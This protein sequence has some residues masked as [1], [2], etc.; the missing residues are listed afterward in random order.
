[1]LKR[2][3]LSCLLCAL[4]VCSLCI[5]ASAA[6]EPN[7]LYINSPQ[8]FLDFSQSCRLDSYSMGLTVYLLRDISLEGLEFSGVPIFSGTFHGMGHRISGVSITQSGSNMGLF[9]FLT[10]TAVVTDLRVEGSIAPGGSSSAAGGIAGSNAGLISGC[11][12]TG[13]VSGSESIGGIAGVNGLSGIIE[14]CTAYG[15]VWGAHF[16][17][18]ITG[19]CTG[20]VRSCEN[21]SDVNA[22]AEQ[23]KLSLSSFSL[24]SLT[25]SESLTAVTDLG[26]IAGTGTGV[27]RDCVNRASVGYPRM[28]YNIGG[29]AGS[30][31]GYI[32]ACE[33]T[34]TV[35]GRKEVGGILGQMEP[36][37]NMLFTED[38]LQI[39]QGQMGGLAA[40]AGSVGAHM[41]SGIASL[42]AQAENI[43]TQTQNVKDAVSTLLPSKEFPFVPDLDTVKAAQ[44][45]VSSSISGINGSLNSMVSIT[46]GTAAT[47]SQDIQNLTGQMGAIG[48][49]IGNASEN[50]GGTVSDVS[51]LDTGEVITA[52][53]ERCRNLGAV[54]GDWNVGGIAG[55]LAVE[56]DLDP[57]S[58]LHFF[59]EYSL[60]F[61]MQLRAVVL[62]CENTGTV[63]GRKLNIGG[64]AGWMSMGLVK[65]CFSAAPVDAASAD[66]T[67]GIAGRSSGY[68][69]HCSVKSAVSGNT[70]TGG[71]AGTGGTVSDCNAMVL[72]SATEKYGAVLGMLEKAQLS[73][74][75]YLVLGSDPGAVDGISYA[76]KAEPADRVSF[77]ATPGLPG[78]FQTVTVTFRYADGT[79]ETRTLDFGDALLDSH[80]PALPVMS[81]CDGCWDGSAQVGA[82]LYFDTVFTAA[83]T[84]HITTL[85]SSA[86]L[87]N[88]L[89]V[90]LV[91]GE[92]RE[93]AALVITPRDD[94]SALE[95]WDIA[96]PESSRSMTLRYRLPEG[97]EAGQVRL[98]LLTDGG[99]EECTFT[100][101][102]S[103]LVF[104]PGAGLKALCLEALP[105]DYTLLRLALGGAAVLTLAIT[106]TVL[107]VRHRKKKTPAVS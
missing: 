15:S 38:A 21:R 27:I 59:G 61:D 97:A 51:D 57:E 78:S 31:S 58:D 12:F 93:G 11:S 73:G 92:F 25:G 1:M 63:S 22:T 87:E 50:L 7:A 98:L 43:D 19:S 80:F 41:Q 82:P 5:P 85:G 64:I 74:N 14:H 30:F 44:T 106:A 66:Y 16:I 18:G 4:L 33:N 56:N 10:A 77:F 32:L 86:T 67:G 6:D 60:N 46:K 70:Y 91:Q 102:G 42:R 34:G 48:N 72:L 20:V 76:G 35:S 47:L 29:I 95:A 55:A 79:A 17:G 84:S 36:A 40:A 107:A 28:G 101:D 81:G 54:S 49:T 99:W 89:P 96:L 8:D 39:L 2:S 105:R 53:V 45:T 52:K 104:T 65:D 26:G 24:E 75:R 9:R 71:I 100:A 103:Y 90:M 83:Y 3:L 88:G 94:A 68:I 37:V 62:A 69:R 23:N 13:T